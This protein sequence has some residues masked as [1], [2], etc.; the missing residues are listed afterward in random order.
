MTVLLH[1]DWRDDTGRGT[2][3]A[4]ITD[5]PYSQRT[6]DGFRTNADLDRRGVGYSAIDRDYCHSLVRE[7]HGRIAWWWAIFGDDISAR[8][9]REALADVGLYTFPPV[10][11]CKVGAAPRFHGDGPAPQCEYLTVARPKGRAFMDWRSL[12]GWYQAGCVRA[13][14]GHMGVTG[15]KPESLMR[16]IVRDYTRPGWSIIDPH[17]GSGTTLVAARAEGRTCVGYEVDPATYAIAKAR[18]EAPYQ[19]D[20]FAFGRPQ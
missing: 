9:W 16:A 19:P 4:M 15:A 7:W 12:P 6:E 3:D 18:I 20:L 2:F 1:M 11:W 5:P 8:W 14:H 10:V 13:G 17:A